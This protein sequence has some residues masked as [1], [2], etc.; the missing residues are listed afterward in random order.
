M[1]ASIRGK[2]NVFGRWSL[3]VGRWPNEISHGFHG[4]TLIK[5]LFI[6]PCESVKSMAV[7]LTLANDQGP[8]T[9]DVFYFAFSQS[10]YAWNEYG[11][12]RKSRTISAA[13][14]VPLAPRTVLRYLAATC[15][16]SNPSFL[17]SVKMSLAM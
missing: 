12:P 9:N 2:D 5:S 10:A 13:G 6:D 3:V 14:L 16:F 4:V 8:K 17:N 15:G 1:R 11:R 7:F